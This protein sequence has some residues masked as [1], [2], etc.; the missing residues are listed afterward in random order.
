MKQIIEV[1]DLIKTYKGGTR[2]VD[3]VSF[4][5]KEGGFFGFLGPNGAGKTTTIRILATLTRL[6]EGQVL[7]NGYDV[8]RDPDAVRASIGFAMQAV[9]LDDLASAWENLLLMG[10]L[11][12]M[13]RAQAKKRA[14]EL[15]QMFKL[16]KVASKYV[17]NYSGGMRRRLDVAV[18]LMHK[19]KVLFLD[20]PTE[21]LDPAG[22]RVIW[23]YL[24]DLNK[25]GT[26]IFLTTHY[27]EEADYL[28]EN[29]AI[30][31]HGKIVAS[32]T[33]SQLKN[34]IGTSYID[35][36][37]ESDKIARGR[38]VLCKK[39]EGLNC[40]LSPNGLEVAIKDGAKT[41][42]LVVK[43]LEQAKIEVINFA[44]RSPSLEDVFLK[45]A[46]ERFEQ[47]DVGKGVDPYMAMRQ[48]RG[49]GARA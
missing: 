28:V 31:N 20:E 39:F 37:L 33:P 43:A 12:G 44:L 21:G 23:K 11:Y 8:N 41:L 45:Y 34:K 22:R 29:L 48:Q 47:E 18:A 46:G 17:A 25:E 15:L 9:G 27:M 40:A 24:Q 19:P 35:L 3:S 32:G 38:E 6:T 42:P 16:E 1:K 4:D 49:G 7:V 30:I 14:E 2:A 26:T 10:G 13:P 36:E 5:V